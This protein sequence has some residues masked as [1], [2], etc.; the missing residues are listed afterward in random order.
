MQRYDFGEAFFAS[1]PSTF[2]RATNRILGSEVVVRRLTV[3]P[4]RAAEL[5]DALARLARS[6]PIASLSLSAWSPH[7]DPDGATARVVEHVFA[8]ARNG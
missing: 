7:L 5:A 6:V 2:Y 3:D 1:G 4:A 8:A